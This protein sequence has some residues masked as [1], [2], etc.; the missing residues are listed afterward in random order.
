MAVAVPNLDLFISLIGALALATLGILFPP[1]L[2]TVAKWNRVSGR[3]KA[4]MIFKNILFGIIGLAG[5]V[6]GTSLSIKDIIKTYL[7]DS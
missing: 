2:E 5:F 7:P 1:F 6:I 3:T 4:I